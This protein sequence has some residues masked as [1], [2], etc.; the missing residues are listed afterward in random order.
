MKRTDY[1]HAVTSGFLN[2]PENKLNDLYKAFSER[3]EL[4]QPAKPGAISLGGKDGN[5][6]EV[7]FTE[8]I[9]SLKKEIINN[10]NLIN[11]DSTTQ[12]L[13]P[14]I[15]G[16]FAGAIEYI[17]QVSTGRGLKTYLLQSDFSP[18]HEISTKQFIELIDAQPAKGKLWNRILYLLNESN[19][20]NNRPSFDASHVKEYILGKEGR[21]SFPRMMSQLM[22]EVQVECEILK[23]PLTISLPLANVFF[24][25]E[26]SFGTSENETVFLYPVKEMEGEEVCRLINAQAGKDEIWA[27]CEKD[28]AE[29]PHP[30]IPALSAKELPEFIRKMNPPLSSSFSNTACRFIREWCEQNHSK[31]VIPA[32]LRDKI[33]PD[34]LEEKRA[35]ARSKLGASQWFL[36]ENQNPWELYCFEEI[37]N[38]VAMKAPGKLNEIKKEFKKALKEAAHFAEK[39]ESPFAEAFKLGEYFLSEGIPSGNF[40]EAHAKLIA[41]DL[42]EEGFSDRALTNFQESFLHSCDFNIFNWVE[43]K[44]YGITA[45]SISDVFGAMGSW[46]DM[47]FE[48]NQD[49]YQKVS[50]DVFRTMKIYFAALLS[51]GN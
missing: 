23:I 44:K 43:S 26:F 48:N 8:W 37:E 40:D 49:E 22:S 31:P 34:E 6:R 41:Q 11:I 28:L 51:S 39:M 16:A 7:N 9:N 47:Y 15:A 4:Y 10:F 14:H 38:P 5:G 46:N 50:A 29:Y 1:L 17:L 12:Y 30:D 18:P 20:L 25:S 19:Q 24:K 45:V 2:A 13:P 33:G 35:Q 3:I 36:K 42:Q 21:E 27:N 32:T